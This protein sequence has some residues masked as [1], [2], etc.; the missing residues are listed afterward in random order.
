MDCFDEA[1]REKIALTCVA[2]AG[3]H[4]NIVRLNEFYHHGGH[5]YLVVDFVPGSTLFDHVRQRSKLTEESVRDILRQVVSA[6]AFLHALGMVHCDLKPDNI[7][8]TPVEAS[9]GGHAVTLIDFGSATIPDPTSSTLPI[10]ATVL[11]QAPPSGTKSYSSPEMCAHENRQ[12]APHVDMWSV[13]CILYIMLCGQH[14]FDPRGNLTE[15]QVTHN[16]LNHPVTF[17][18]PIWATISPC[19]KEIVAALLEKDP[20]KRMTA[21]MLS[22]ELRKLDNDNGGARFP[23]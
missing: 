6:I 15:A 3:G 2:A 7:M 10:D 11:A 17:D 22:K 9:G 19:M 13:G 18:Q 5:H 12:V 14:P 1:E 8:I 16:I 21:D 23:Q 20:E 4:V